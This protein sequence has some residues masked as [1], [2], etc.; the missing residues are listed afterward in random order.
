MIGFAHLQGSI[1]EKS[2]LTFFGAE[3]F[4]MNRIID[5]TQNDFTIFLQGNGNTKYRQTIDV[6]GGSVEGVND[7][8]EFG[9][10]F[11][12]AAFFCQNGVFGKMFVKDRYNSL[13]R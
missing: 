3:H 6:V 10:L 13:L 5:N 8:A 9:I 1:I 11:R 4:L 2:T 7:P 12:T